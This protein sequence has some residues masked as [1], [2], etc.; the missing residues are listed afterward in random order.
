MFGLTIPTYLR[1][2]QRRWNPVILVFYRHDFKRNKHHFLHHH[3]ECN[4][5][6][7]FSFLATSQCFSSFIAQEFKCRYYLLYSPVGG[8][9]ALVSSKLIFYLTRGENMADQSFCYLSLERRGARDFLLSTMSITSWTSAHFVAQRH[10]LDPFFE[11]KLPQS[12]FSL[13]TIKTYAS[14]TARISYSRDGLQF[15]CCVD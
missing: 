4:K 9:E 12:D 10:F 15:H 2:R 11:Q 8:I 1:R 13:S 6:W 7:N 3:M 14:L 5:I